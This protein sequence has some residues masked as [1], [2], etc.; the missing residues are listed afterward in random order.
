MFSKLFA[1]KKILWITVAVISLLAVGG[2]YAFRNSQADSDSAD[3]PTMQ[4]AKIRQGDLTL[5]AS[6]TGT[7]IPVPCKNLNRSI[8]L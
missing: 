1:N 2:L 6:G 5:Y 4:T 7:L 3:A 8:L